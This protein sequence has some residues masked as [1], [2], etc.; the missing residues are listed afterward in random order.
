MDD[1]VHR[2]LAV[3]GSVVS[4]SGSSL[5]LGSIED[6]DGDGRRTSQASEPAHGQD[7]SVVVHGCKGRLAG[8]NACGGRSERESRIQPTN[9]GSVKHYVH[10]LTNSPDSRCTY[11]THP[12]HS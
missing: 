10:T 8:Y 2:R 9:L 11:H 7:R 4:S 6:E 5:R 12:D 1:D 3:V